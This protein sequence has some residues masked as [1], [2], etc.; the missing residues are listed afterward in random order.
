MS[1]LPRHYRKTARGLNDEVQRNQDGQQGAAFSIA[2]DREQEA[3][4][5]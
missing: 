1:Q 4:G 5:L 2:Q 3:D